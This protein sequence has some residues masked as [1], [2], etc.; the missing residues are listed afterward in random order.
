MKNLKIG[1][2][3]IGKLGTAMMAH[4]QKANI[5]IGVYHP[6][7]MKAQ[8]FIQRFPNGH[9]LAEL[10]LRDLDI[11]LL[12]VPAGKVIPFIES[13]AAIDDSSI[14]FINMATSLPTREISEKFPAYSVYGVKYMG[15][16]RDLLEHGNGLFIT[17]NQL[18]NE[19][20]ALFNPLGKIEIDR[21]ERLVGV[22]K[23]A[24]YYAVKIAVEIENEFTKQG[25]PPSYI[26]RVLTSLA[27]E[28]IRSYSQG[29]L[30]HFAQEIVKE[31]REEIEIDA[32]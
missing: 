26:K 29:N 5:E 10:E 20:M 24:T 9:L 6:N 1:L 17:G 4:W 14:S 11:L 12:A 22:N 15:H 28:V 16:S 7:R 21:E 27:P 25:Y 23:L 8:Q 31:I 18:P 3:G 2:A 19:V 13:M 32:D 30:G